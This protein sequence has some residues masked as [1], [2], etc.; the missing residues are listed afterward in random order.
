MIFVLFFSKHRPDVEVKG[1]APNV[2][3][4]PVVLPFLSVAGEK[5]HL[6]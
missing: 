4:K 1:L 2:D 6:K 3:Y 5:V